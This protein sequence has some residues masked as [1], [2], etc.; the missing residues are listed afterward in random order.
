MTAVTPLTVKLGGVAGTSVA[1]LAVIAREADASCVV[2]HGGGPELADWQRRLGLEPQLS[3]GLRVTDPATLEVAVA[4]LA[5][6][7]NTR[8]VAA[9]AAAGRAAIGLTG[10]DACLLTLERADASLGEVGLPVGADIAVLD[11]LTGAGLLP[12]VSSI[13]RDADGSLLNVNADAAAGAIAAARGG[14]LLLCSDVAGVMHNGNMVASLTAREAEAMVAA[15]VAQGGMVPK[16]EAAMVAA[17]AG[18][19]VSI[20]DGRA[21]ETLA[22]ALAGEA[23]GTRIGADVEAEVSA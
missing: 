6:L 3:N 10:A 20:L 5:G 23:V 13:G 11:V 17:R 7:V 2:V 16:L 22:A 8:L 9:F 21:P 1:S 14:R 12:V 18:C 15:G 4:V 19:S